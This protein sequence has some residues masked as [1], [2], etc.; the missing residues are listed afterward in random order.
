MI[1]IKDTAD[2]F[3][4]SLFLKSSLAI[5]QSVANQW[6]ACGVGAL[7]YAHACALVKARPVHLIVENTFFLRIAE[8]CRQSGIVVPTEELHEAFVLFSK[9]PHSRRI[10]QQRALSA[11]EISSD[12]EYMAKSEAELALHNGAEIVTE[13]T[14]I[15][16]SSSLMDLWYD[17]R[18]MQVLYDYLRPAGFS[19][20][21]SERIGRDEREEY[22]DTLTEAGT[23]YGVEIIAETDGEK[24]YMGDTFKVSE[25]SFQLNTVNDGVWQDI[26]TCYSVGAAPMAFA[27]AA[28][29]GV[30]EWAA[31]RIKRA[32][33]IIAPC[34]GRLVW[35]V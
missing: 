22:T 6:T 33:K 30:A 25:F 13:N 5:R 19:V 23:T 34:Q 1:V 18:L 21:D 2:L 14:P 8:L 17:R 20:Y 3:A 16:T 4:L 11:S 32:M 31:L 9:T 29:D 15:Q 35:F 12:E 28:P 27:E 24:H 26:A 10:R 7:N